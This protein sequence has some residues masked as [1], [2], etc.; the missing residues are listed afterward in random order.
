MTFEPLLIFTWADG[1]GLRR[2]F[3]GLDDISNDVFVL[4]ETDHPL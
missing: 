2:A 4:P 3:D 1:A